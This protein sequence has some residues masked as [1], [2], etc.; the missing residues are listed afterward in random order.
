L[1][2]TMIILAL[3]NVDLLVIFRN[4]M[5]YFLEVLPEPSAL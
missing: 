1:A 4:C 5:N 2:K 3:S